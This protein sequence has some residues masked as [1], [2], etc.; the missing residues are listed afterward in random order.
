M[1]KLLS[2]LS[3]LTISGTSVPTTIAASL[4][5]KEEKLNIIKIANDDCGATSFSN[6]KIVTPALVISDEAEDDS[7]KKSIKEIIN[8]LL[9]NNIFTEVFASTSSGIKKYSIN[10]TS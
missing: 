8:F 9:E 5:Q 7:Y 6:K 2:L 10:Q 1:K 4:Y 3:V